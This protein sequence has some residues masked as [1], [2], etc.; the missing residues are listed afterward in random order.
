MDF[1]RYLILTSHV[2][3][4]YT[5][6]NRKSGIVINLQGG[7]SVINNTAT[8]IDTTNPSGYLKTK[9]DDVN[10]RKGIWGDRIAIVKKAGTEFPFYGTPKVISDSPISTAG[11][12][13]L[14]PSIPQRP[15]RP[16]PDP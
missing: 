7:T 9:I 12:S 8:S 13:P 10:V 16:I 14:P 5:L 11:L 6:Y 1:I 2:N 15:P 4:L 3:A